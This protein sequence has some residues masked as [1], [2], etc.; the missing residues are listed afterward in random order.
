MTPRV[1]QIIT[2]IHR[3]PGRQT[4]YHVVLTCKHRHSV[5]GAEL[6]WQQ[7]FMGKAVKCT[8]CGREHKGQIQE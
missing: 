2:R 1:L 5:T 4:A 6:E 7:L 8:E 3:L